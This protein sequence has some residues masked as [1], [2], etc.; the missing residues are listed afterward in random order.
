MASVF[1]KSFTKPVPAGAETFTRKGVLYAR[2]IQRGKTR[3]ERATMAEDGTLRLLLEA[4]TYTARYRDGEGV[5]REVATGLECGI[6]LDVRATDGSL[7]N[8]KRLL[9][10]GSGVDVALLQ[11]GV[12][13][14]RE[15]PNLV[16]L[17]RL[18][19]ERYRDTYERADNCAA[20]RRMLTTFCV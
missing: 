16:S 18:F 17:G 3:T 12:T 1:K 9:D 19:V 6:T 4:T 14:S 15:A 2:W 8:V 7:D 5:V 10:P 11:G 20:V 13:N